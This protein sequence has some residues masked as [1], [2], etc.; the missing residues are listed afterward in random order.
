MSDA[1]VANER[2]CDDKLKIV[3]GTA[4]IPTPISILTVSFG[5][6]FRRCFDPDYGEW[7]EDRG[8]ISWIE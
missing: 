6:L 4:L 8:I 2:D 1:K 5:I 3:K 7:V